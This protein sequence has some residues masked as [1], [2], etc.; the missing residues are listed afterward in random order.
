M[1]G[2]A[3]VRNSLTLSG[4]V[5]RIQSHLNV[6]GEHRNKQQS[7]KQATGTAGLIISQQG[8]GAQLS[9]TLTVS[10]R[11]GRTRQVLRHIRV[12]GIRD[13]EV[14]CTHHSE[15]TS[16]ASSRALSAVLFLLK[17][18]HAPIMR[19][20]EAYSL[21][22]GTLNRCVFDCLKCG[23]GTSNRKHCSKAGKIGDNGTT[24][25]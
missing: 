9:Y 8:S 6:R 20:S 12:E 18:T 13:D 16:H 14:Q 15:G 3:T 23:L 22:Q 1:Q 24:C 5:T 4:L 25:G 11:V 17:N 2:Q 10:V 19:P 21:A 7:R